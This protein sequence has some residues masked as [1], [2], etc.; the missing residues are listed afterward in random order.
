MGEEVRPEQLNDDEL[1]RALDDLYDY[2]AD[3]LFRDLAAHARG[4]AWPHLAVCPAGCDQFF[5]RG[6]VRL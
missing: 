1:G 3:G 2:G 5:I 6:R 4:E